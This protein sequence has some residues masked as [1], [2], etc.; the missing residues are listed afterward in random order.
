MGVLLSAISSPREVPLALQAYE[1]SRKQRA[2]TVQQSGTDNRITLHLPDGPEQ[3]ARDEQFRAS[4]NGASNPDKWA[5]RETQKFLWG[6]DEE[7]HALQAWNGALCEPCLR[8]SS[9]YGGVARKKQLLTFLLTEIV[10]AEVKVNA[11]L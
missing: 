2:D 5:D 11:S 4:M 3:R 6:W 8:P 1:K 10:G 9:I 7:E